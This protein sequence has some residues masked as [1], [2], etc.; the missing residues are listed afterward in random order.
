MFKKYAA[1]LVFLFAATAAYAGVYE[2][3]HNAAEGGIEGLFS[4]RTGKIEALLNG[5]KMTIER[6]ESFTAPQDI[7]E[8]L[9]Q[10]YEGEGMRSVD[11]Y[12]VGRL[13]RYLLDIKEPRSPVYYMLYEGEKGAVLAAAVATQRGSS[14]VTAGFMYRG[15]KQTGGYGGPVRPHPGME[16]KLSIELLSTGRRAGYAVF[17]ST[18]CSMAEVE[19]Y[20]DDLL[21][22]SGW[23][24]KRKNSD[25]NSRFYFASKMGRECVTAL[26]DE[27]DAVWLVV[28]G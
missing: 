6:R 27:A 16:K 21:S 4:V 26:F 18:N 2:A 11:Y 7:M 13:A 25:G 17:Y 24:L 12:D 3:V 10:R 19:A 9:G 1:A 23:E 5:E 22:K 28:M 8:R 20:F 14:Y 15:L